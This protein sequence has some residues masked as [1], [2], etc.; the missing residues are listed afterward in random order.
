MRIIFLILTEKL[1]EFKENNY[2]A[3]LNR[4]NKNKTVYFV[5]IVV[6]LSATKRAFVYKG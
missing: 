1:N 5:V 3:P 4:F 6:A 2:Y